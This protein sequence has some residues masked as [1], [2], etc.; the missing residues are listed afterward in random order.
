MD[1]IR[2][3]RIFEADWPNED[4]QSMPQYIGQI[5]RFDGMD[6]M[7]V[8]QRMLFI[9][10][11]ELFGFEGFHHLY[12]N[13]TPLLPHGQMQAAKRTY[14]REDS[15]FRFV[16]IGCEVETFNSWHFEKK[17]E[18]IVSTMMNAV[19]LMTREADRSVAAEC[20][21]EVLEKGE[22][23]LLPY[24]RKENTDYDVEIQLRITDEPDFI[25]VILISRKNGEIV[26]KKELRG[27]GRD[28]F[29]C[30]FRSVS[31]GKAS[32]RISPR[33][34]YDSEFYGLK[35]IKLSW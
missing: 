12:L 8:I 30:Q 13:Y 20:I 9:L 10:R 34:N 28:E 32:I 26:C 14:S 31:I 29:I 3:I 11:S 16:D 27:Y 21:R 25:P 2:D 4:Y 19:L 33:R 18:F 6:V 23:L 1:Q 24:K 15:W 7:D 5:Y 35:P 17:T 22:N